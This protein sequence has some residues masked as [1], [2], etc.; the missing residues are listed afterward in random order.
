MS[1]V[2]FDMFRQEENER[3]ACHDSGL[4]DLET[5]W[6]QRRN[7]RWMQLGELKIDDFKS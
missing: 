3:K 7:V 4:E 6:V 5:Q 1:L 2:L